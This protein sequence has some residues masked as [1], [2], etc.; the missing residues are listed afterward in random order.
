VRPTRVDETWRA[1]E[2][3]RLHVARLAREKALAAYSQDSALPV[4]GADTT[5]V[6]D[7]ELFGKPRSREEGLAMLMRLSGRTHEVLTAVALVVR[8]VVTE[9]LSVS[10]VAFRPLEEAECEAYWDTGEPRDKAGA[11]AIQGRAALFVSHLSG[12]YSGVM[13][14]PVFETAELLREAALLP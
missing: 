5:V 6:L 11:Y 13:G 9:R 12:S 14:L 1:G 3:A 2:T 4:L 7:D 8:G 10:H